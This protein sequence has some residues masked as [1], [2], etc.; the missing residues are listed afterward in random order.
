MK[1]FLSN[2]VCESCGRSREWKYRDTTYQPTTEIHACKFCYIMWMQKQYTKMYLES[3]EE[4]NYTRITTNEKWSTVGGLMNL[5][6][7]RAR[8][9]YIGE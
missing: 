3:W 9:K 6:K 7:L 2:E 5:V 1:T 8:L 4:S